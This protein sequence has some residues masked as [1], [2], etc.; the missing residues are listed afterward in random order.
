MKLVTATKKQFPVFY[1]T[2]LYKWTNVT[3]V[4]EK[5]SKNTLKFLSIQHGWELYH[6]D[7]M[8]I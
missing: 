6:I 8:L 5:E 7:S 4:F 2:K 3:L 1:L